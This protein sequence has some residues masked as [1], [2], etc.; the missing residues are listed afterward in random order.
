[1]F[2]KV[3]EQGRSKREGEA[4]AFRYVEPWSD[5]QL[6]A[7]FNIMLTFFLRASEQHRRSSLLDT[8]DPAT[9]SF[10]TCRY[11]GKCIP[12]YTGAGPSRGCGSVR[13]PG[14]PAPPLRC[15]CRSS[16]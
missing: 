11:K 2:K 9:S 1:M 15:S 13:I 5:A 10:R 14:T 8:A 7:F 12:E 4:Y 6:E 16:R 3:F